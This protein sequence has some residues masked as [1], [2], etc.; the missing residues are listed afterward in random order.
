MGTVLALAGFAIVAGADLRWF[1]LLQAVRIPKD[2][3]V[4]LAL[5]ATGALLGIGALL[6]GTGALAGILAVLAA[7]GGL[8]FLGLWA[9]SGQAAATPAVAVGGPILDFVASDDEGN[10]FDLGALRGKPLL[11]KFFRGHW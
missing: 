2:R 1:Q 10:R 6:L 11:L 9:A 5:N 7:V 8:A 4:F 3:T